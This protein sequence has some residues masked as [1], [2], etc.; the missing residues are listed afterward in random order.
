MPGAQGTACIRPRAVRRAHKEAST[1]QTR[2]RSS[3][4]GD[5][6]AEA[7]AGGYDEDLTLNLLRCKVGCSTDWP[8]ASGFCLTHGLKTVTT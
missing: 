1:A 4:A 7:L 3:E 8:G 6:E 2:T 5:L